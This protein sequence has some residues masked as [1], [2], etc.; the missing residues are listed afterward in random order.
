MANSRG[1]PKSRTAKRKIDRAALPANKRAT[2]AAVTP[3]PAKTHRMAWRIVKVGAAFIVGV[4]GLIASLYAILG[5][6]PWPTRLEIGPGPPEQSHAFDVPFSVFNPSGLFDALHAN[7]LCELDDVAF[8]NGSRFIN[9]LT[10]HVEENLIGRRDRRPFRCAFLG[11]TAV[12]RARIR[13]VATYQFWLLRSWTITTVAGPFV[14]DRRTH[15]PR[16]L[17]EPIGPT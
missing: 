16:W 17:K 15:P 2:A 9:T 7:F 3:P 10:V 6:P 14:W 5:G 8:E 11:Q 1:R 13:I 4:I 12:T